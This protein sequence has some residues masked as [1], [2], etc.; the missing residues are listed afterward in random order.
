MN[1][2]IRKR[3]KELEKK[4]S[5]IDDF[6][7]VTVTFI[8]GSRKEMLWCDII[9]KYSENIEPIVKLESKNPDLVSL[10]NCLLGIGLG[11]PAEDDTII[12]DGL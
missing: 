9:E 11:L 4:H 6:T 12:V 3:L 7:M 2:N 5:S 1:E 8:D 10:L